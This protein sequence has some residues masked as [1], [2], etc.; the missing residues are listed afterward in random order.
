MRKPKRDRY[1]WHQCWH[2]DA[3]NGIEGLAPDEVGVY[4]R[5]IL[6]MYKRRSALRDDDI[7]MARLCETPT[8]TYRRIRAALIGKGR[9]VV[10]E[11]NGL[12]YD[13][14]ALAELVA[15][16]RFSQA[17]TDRAKRKWGGKTER[18]PRLRVVGGKDRSESASLKQLSNNFDVTSAPVVENIEKTRCRSDANHK[19]E[20]KTSLTVQRPPSARRPPLNRGG[21]P[22]APMTDEERAAKL[23]D[24]RR[25]M[26]LDDPQAPDPPSEVGDR[27]CRRA[28]S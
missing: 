23:A 19:P 2:F 7:E 11:E 18:K 6:M 8:R 16:E 21:A 25:R 9:I 12:I 13:E 28:A 4:W 20:E 3:W 5:I 27:T 22:T 1:A 26:G 15:A 10:D 14:R 24:Q 17:Q